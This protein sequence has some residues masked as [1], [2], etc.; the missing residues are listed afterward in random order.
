M[1]MIFTVG[2]PASGKSTYAM[3]QVAARKP[4]IV[5]VN[6]DDIRR[7]QFGGFTGEQ[8]DENLVTFIAQTMING[9]FKKDRSVIISDT[10]LNRSIVRGN[11]QIA[12]KWGATVRFEY[13][14]VDVE[15]CIRRDS[16]RIEAV[17]EKVIRGMYNR[18]ARNGLPDF[19]DLEGPGF[20]RVAYV[21]VEGTPKAIIV[22]LDGTV[23]LHDRSPYDYDQ[24]HT[25]RPN[26]HVVQA[27]RDEYAKG[28]HILFTSGRPDSHYRETREWLRD[29]LSLY[30]RLPGRAGGMERIELFMRQTADKRM[31][32]IVKYEIFD[33]E[34]RNN[35][36]VKYCLDDRNQVVDMWRS[37]DLNVWQVNAGDF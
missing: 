16:N 8:T 3:K 34:I 4:E 12:H 19:S 27:V 33:R 32:A 2:L 14:E 25:D 1:E 26:E 18:Y 15:E 36:D 5:N 20:N 35:F 30:P 9:A 11:I 29:N 13:F 7:M 21:P 28:T 6:R 37:I 23:A 22:D 17:G 10:N 24:L 31:D